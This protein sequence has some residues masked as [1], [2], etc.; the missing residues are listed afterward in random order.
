V[1]RIVVEDA[2]VAERGRPRVSDAQ[3]AMRIP[4]DFIRR[5]D[6]L[7]TRILKRDPA[8]LGFAR[9]ATR[10]QIFRIALD[11]GLKQLEERF[12]R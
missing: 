11:L 2:A 1:V 8:L 10:S 3:T 4:T 12:P 9:S 7:R 5:A 6:A